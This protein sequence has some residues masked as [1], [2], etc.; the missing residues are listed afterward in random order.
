M[1]VKCH[2]N[3]ELKYKAVMAHLLTLYGGG[4]ILTRLLLVAIVWLLLAIWASLLVPITLRL[5]LVSWLL[6]AL[7]WHVAL[8][9]WRKP[10]ARRIALLRVPM[11][12]L[13]GTRESAQ[14][15]QRPVS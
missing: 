5:A 1:R 3:C 13:R 15:G 4:L 14:M 6:E 11:T 12:C 7:L 8:L 2:G 10:R 9:L